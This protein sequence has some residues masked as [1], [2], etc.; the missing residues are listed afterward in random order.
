MNF[1]LRKNCRFCHKEKLQ[2][3]TPN[4]FDWLR[5]IFCIGTYFCPHCFDVFR[6]PVRPGLLALLAWACCYFSLYVF[7][8]AP[9]NIVQYEWPDQKASVV[10]QFVFAPLI[11]I[12]P[13]V[14]EARLNFESFSTPVKEANVAEEPGSTVV[15]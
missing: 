7:T 2:P 6:R 5:S 3:A 13:R 4:G 12:D 14:R 10:S 1:G 15:R 8:T 11:K 9:V